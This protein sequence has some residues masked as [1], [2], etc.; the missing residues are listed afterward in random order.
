[1][2]TD[3]DH[4]V[5]ETTL[6]NGEAVP[7]LAQL[8]EQHYAA[9]YRFAYRL[10]GSSADAEDLVQQTFLTAHRKIGQ[11]RDPENGKSWLFTITRNTYLKSIRG[12]GATQL[13]SLDDAP[14][15][16]EDCPQDIRLDNE[17]IQAVLNE[18]EE[19]FRTPII[20][21]YFEQFSYKEIAEQM[22]V[23]IGTVMSRLA[24]GK[25]HLRQKLAAFQPAESQ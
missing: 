12:N 2:Q 11:L 17:Q 23:P 10:S 15:P 9:L 6:A 22:E 5:S 25:A 7:L 4:S 21:F 8:V 3:M 13:I 24:R 18:L 14:E 19:E 20:L 1:M 16:G